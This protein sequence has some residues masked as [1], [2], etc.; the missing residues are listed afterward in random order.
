MGSEIS[1]FVIE[2]IMGIAAVALIAF[3][4]IEENKKKNG[5]LTEQS[6]AKGLAIGA[7]I[8]IA[9]LIVVNLILTLIAG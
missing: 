3:A 9:L 8:V 7:I 1:S 6:K 2:P 5:K 4:I